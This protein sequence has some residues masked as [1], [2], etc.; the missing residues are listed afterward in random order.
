MFSFSRGNQARV[1]LLLAPFPVKMGGP[2]IC[3]A[4]LFLITLTKLYLVWVAGEGRTNT[5]KTHL[6]RMPRVGWSTHL[7]RLGP[8]K[9]RPWLFYTCP[10][11]CRAFLGADSAAQAVNLAFH[12]VSLPLYTYRAPLV[13]CNTPSQC[14]WHPWDR[15]ACADPHALPESCK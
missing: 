15:G 4:L 7:G 1:P 13:R 9:L 2:Q 5:W 14:P 6:F 10:A 12:N 8:L 11:Q 3:W